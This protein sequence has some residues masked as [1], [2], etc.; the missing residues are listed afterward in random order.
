ML[1][2]AV[3]V[4]SLFAAACI[5]VILW[6]MRDHGHSAPRIVAYELLVWWAWAAATPVVAWLGRRAPFSA[7]MAAMHVVAAVALGGAHVVWWSALEVAMQPFDAMGPQTV[8]QALRG[9]LIDN[10]FL[11]VSLY[12]AVLGATYAMDY[13][14]RL[15][16]REASLAQARLEA[17]QGQLRP[18][19]LFNTLHAI[20]GLVRQDRGPEAIAM[21][22]G[23]SDLL[24]YSLDHGSA[25]LVPL[26][27]E[28]AIT[29]RYLEIQRQRFSDRLDTK[30]DAGA[31]VARAHVP[32]LLLQPLVENAVRHGVERASGRGVIEVR[33]AR[34]GDELV[35]EVFNSGPAPGAGDAGIGLDNTRARLGQLFPGACSLELVAVDGGALARVRIPHREAP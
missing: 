35:V 5:A 13:Q 23:L 26:D 25:Q 12:A 31:D 19:F 21:I 34:Q 22:T 14:R 29:E 9:D 27:Q 32:V 4:W 16:E 10:L 30:I 33:A 7:R 1:R 18:H 17:L 11:E 24:R 6:T 3:V 8:A 2:A 28:L 15:R 20:G